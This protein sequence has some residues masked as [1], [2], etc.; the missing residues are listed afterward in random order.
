MRQ[1][2]STSSAFA[3]NFLFL[4]GRDSHGNWVVQDQECR[5]GGLF[6]DRASALK[7]A[8]LENGHQQPAVTMVPGVFEFA[9]NRREEV[10][11]NKADVAD[12]QYTRI[13]A[14]GRRMA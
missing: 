5:C 3:T 10:A 13:P 11:S 12:N 7:F 8:T 2:D 6:V 14:R 9:I 4:M 1:P